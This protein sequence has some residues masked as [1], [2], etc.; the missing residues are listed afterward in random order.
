MFVGAIFWNEEYSHTFFACFSVLDSSL[1]CF[2]VYTWAK[3]CGRFF[4]E[5]GI[6]HLIRLFICV[7]VLAA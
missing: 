3:V 2:F 6:T 4:L 5:R 7:F 1:A